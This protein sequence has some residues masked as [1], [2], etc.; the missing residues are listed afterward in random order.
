MKNLVPS[1]RRLLD[2]KIT[3]SWA[4]FDWETPAILT[5]HRSRR[6]DQAIAD[7]APLGLVG[8][9]HDDDDVQVERV[10]FMKDR[11]EPPTG[12]FG[13][14]EFLKVK[15]SRKIGKGRGS[16]D[17][18]R[19]IRRPGDLYQVL[20]RVDT[21]GRGTRSIMDVEH[22]RARRRFTG[23][24]GH[25]LPGVCNLVEA[26]QALRDRFRSDRARSKDAEGG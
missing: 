4:V 5:R 26:S 16:E 19:G 1:F 21:Q 8:R 25:V 17:K 13:L 24:P 10:P 15:C 6:P 12:G 14:S 20:D 23:R 11:I 3:R 18:K 2:S 7:G 22:S 9:H